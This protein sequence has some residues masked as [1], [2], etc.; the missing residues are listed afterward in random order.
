[1]EDGIGYKIW[2]K[3]C[4]AIG[5][6]VGEFFYFVYGG[7]VT[8]CNRYKKLIIIYV[9]LLA[10][11]YVSFDLFQDNTLCIYLLLLTIFVA[12]IW[13]Y[14]IEYPEVQLRKKFQA[15]F[16]NLKLQA[17][18][19]SFPHLQWQEHNEYCTAYCFYTLLPI[20]EFRK[21]LEDLEMYL[22]AKIVDIVQDQSNNRI[23][24]IIVQNASLPRRIDWDDK[25][26]VSE[27]FAIGIGYYDLVL[28]DLKKYPHT[29]ITGT[30]GTGK[31]N[32]LK[33]M[34]HQALMKEY[35]ITLIDFK[36]AVSFVEFSDYVDI[37]YEHETTKELLEQLVEETKRRLDMFRENRVEDIDSYNRYADY[38]KRISRKI[39]FIDELAELLQIRDKELS[40]SLYDSLET[41]TRLSR[42]AGIHLIIGMQR[43]D[44][45]LITGQIKANVTG[46][47][48]GRFSDKESSRII[49]GNDIA[50]T[51]RNIDGRFIFKDDSFVE[52]QCFYFQ[53][54]N[55]VE[56]PHKKKVVTTENSVAE[57]NAGELKQN[58]S[59][60]D[61]EPV[62]NFSDI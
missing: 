24:Y 46:R 29:F 40:H 5:Y 22:N 62:F 10:S 54:N 48:C 15:I 18:D 43:V 21:K 57:L 14:I 27:G 31:S 9:A 35:E 12:S 49:L 51:L 33:C 23:I 56:Y 37:Y 30:T 52:V 4:Y 42:S 11:I 55:Y 50:T 53:N 6:L 58:D 1:M 45:S 39:V 8:M 2:Y 59:V 61:N 17:I 32:I 20:S 7:I 60:N 16:E 25:Y 3:L 41:L 47:L 38:R 19:S 36:R 28:L 44:S 26:L 13:N 34:I